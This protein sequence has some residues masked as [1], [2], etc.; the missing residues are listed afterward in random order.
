MSVVLPV[1]DGA[2][3]N[4]Y[5]PLLKLSVLCHSPLWRFF[6]LSRSGTGITP[7]N[8]SCI[9]CFVKT[10]VRT[11]KGKTPKPP[12]GGFL[13]LPVICDGGDHYNKKDV[14]CAR[15]NDISVLL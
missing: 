7:C 12:K 15:L 6:I 13:L 8:D 4:T 3:I 5:S 10:K 2:C 14:R 11:G 1:P 9:C